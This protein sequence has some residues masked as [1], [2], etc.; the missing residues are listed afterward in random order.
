MKTQKECLALHLGTWYGIFSETTF[1]NQIP[2]EARHKRSQIIFEQPQPEVISQSNAYLPVEA[3]N[4]DLFPSAN[5]WYY[6]NFSAGLRFFEE[7]SFSNGRVQLAPFSDFATEQGFLFENQKMRVVQQFDSQG[8]ISAITTI[9]EAR[10]ENSQAWLSQQIASLAE[11]VDSSTALSEFFAEYENSRW[12]GSATTLTADHYT[13]SQQSVTLIMGRGND[14]CWLAAPR[15]LL[16]SPQILPIPTTH[17][18]R[19]FQIELIWL[20]NPEYYLG[21]IRRYDRQGAWQDITLI[22]ADRW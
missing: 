10:G 20:P 5:P 8:R 3:E 1:F 4:E 16:R 17:R 19:H 9:Q 12:H 21:L 6:Q 14:F 18:D 2:T 15:L 22:Q 11:P 13:P 7:G